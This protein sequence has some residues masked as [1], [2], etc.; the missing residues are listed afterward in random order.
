MKRMHTDMTRMAYLEV[1]IFLCSMVTFMPSNCETESENSNKRA[2]LPKFLSEL[3]VSSVEA[4]VESD[5]SLK[6]IVKRLA[7]E[8]NGVTGQPG[9]DF[10]ALTTIPVTS[11][12]CRGLKGGYYADLET[13][14]QVFHICDNGR[15]ISF[16][17]PNGTIFQQS[18]LICDWWF[19]VDCSKSTELYEQSSEELEEER[20]RAESRKPKLDYQQSIENGGQQDY[21]DVQNL[22]YDGRQNG[23]IKTYERPPEN[24]VQSNRERIKQSRHFDTGNNFHQESNVPRDSNLFGAN[25]FQSGQASK[26]NQFAR[27]TEE[28]N[29]N[30]Y[31]TT[32][33]NYYSTPKKAQNYHVTSRN[34]NNQE[35]GALKRLKFKSSTR[36]NSV[37]TVSQRVT[38]AYTESTTFRAGNTTPIKESQQVAESA[39]F[40]GNRA[41]RFD[42]NSGNSHQ[43]YYQL[44]VNRDSSTR[45][46]DST[47]WRQEN[48]ISTQREFLPL[49]TTTVPYE[50][51][52]YST[53]APCNDEVT[54]EITVA[55]SPP[56]FPDT[57]PTTEPFPNSNY[58]YRSSQGTTVR[59]TFVNYYASDNNNDRTDASN[60]GTPSTTRSYAIV[61][62]YRRN[63]ETPSSVYLKFTTPVQSFERSTESPVTGIVD[64]QY[65]KFEAKPSSKNPSTISPGYRQNF[66]SSTTEKPSRTTVFYQPT[67]TERDLSPYDR[68][69]TYKQGKVMSTLGPYVPF[70]RNYYSNSTTSKPTPY[71]PTVPTYTSAKTLIPKLKYPTPTTLS[72]LK[73]NRLSEREHALS[74]LHSLR[75]LEHKVPSL[76]DGLKVEERRSNASAPP[77]PSTLHSLALYFSTVTE[78]FE[79]NETTDSS[80]NFE[81]EEDVEKSVITKKSNGTVQVPAGLLTEHTVNSY[82]ELFKL[83]DSSDSNNLTTEDRSDNTSYS[84][85]YN[86]DLELQQS[87]GS[88]DE[89]RKSNSTKLRELAQVFTHALSAYLLDP[90]SFKRVLTEIRPTEPPTTTEQWRTTTAYSDAEDYT[91]S[92]KEKD[93][94]LEFSDDNDI[95]QK[96]T[97]DYSTTFEPSTTIKDNVESFSTLPSTYYTTPRTSFQDVYEPS[98]NVVTN[99]ATS[100]YFDTSAPPTEDT[101]TADHPSTSYA[102]D[103]SFHSQKIGKNVGELVTDN[104]VPSD[105]TRNR[106]G[107]FQN[108]S[109][110]I[111]TEPYGDKPFVTTPINDNHLVSP[112]PSAPSV[113]LHMVTHNWKQ[114]STSK[115]PEQ[116]LTPPY[117][118]T[119]AETVR[120]DSERIVSKPENYGSTV[121]VR[122]STTSRT[123]DSSTITDSRTTDPDRITDSR[124]TEPSR[125]TDSKTTDPR[126]H[127]PS[128]HK[129]LLPESKPVPASSFTKFRDL[130]NRVED[131]TETTERPLSTTRVPEYTTTYTDTTPCSN[132]YTESTNTNEESKLNDDHWT[133]SPAVTRLWET[134]VFVDPQ[135][136]NHGLE[137]DLGTT[138]LA[139]SSTENQDQLDYTNMSLQEEVSD[140]SEEFLEDL[141]L[142]QRLSRD[143][144]SPTTFSLFPTTFTT[145]TVTPRPLTT[146]PSITTIASTKSLPNS[147]LTS[148]VSVTPI[149]LSNLDKS[150][151]TE[152][153]I[154]E[155]L[156]GKL[157]VSSTNTLMRVMKQADSNETVRQLVLLLVQHCSD[158]ANQTMQRE[159]EEL[160]KTLLELPVNEFSSEESKNIVA[161]INQLSLPAR[162]N[163]VRSAST[164]A[165]VTDPPVT[166]YRSRKSRKF[167][168]TTEHSANFVRRAEK[169]TTNNSLLEDETTVS[170]NRA[171]ELLRSLYTIA[172]KW[173]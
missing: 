98:T 38:P 106:V 18:Q 121:T 173:G 8:K 158:L 12:S 62:N 6:K 80:I 2:S 90:D 152:S 119:H 4:S 13:N 69:F 100:V 172:T 116:Q 10:P 96:L 30:R 162:S 126:A 28:G 141:P 149:G 65:N 129:S 166:T 32:S 104:Y 114:K 49:V 68:S 58:D 117:F 11:F 7:P 46:Y 55:T 85:D 169:G 156:F 51:T 5:E 67:M 95:R 171:L 99:S 144:D 79:S 1:I 83:N 154:A 105:E 138:T 75:N 63:T 26:F 66:I 107:G 35:K 44:Y 125:I 59:S 170:D 48:D 31:S 64:S 146:R 57:P 23:R 87:G 61:D 50:T 130:Y 168:T 159:K 118:E 139:D 150:N 27:N 135:R 22:N 77:A 19:K 34:S 45:N 84:E 123:T 41:N 142:T 37:P 82:V 74:M 97:T 33:Q 110:S 53:V 3:D 157:N 14:C 16:L 131:H 109:A 56:T 148:T 17:C 147:L 70:T 60:S 103:T 24:Q 86:D 145:E 124:T 132:D 92:I 43:Y 78:N 91:S 93:E 155:K 164:T 42:E 71:T 133:S 122:S 167:R 25:G 9:V 108:N 120:R 140:S 101:F 72:K 52:Q 20:R 73:N 21:Y 29:V 112:T 137:S 151:G 39:A 94:V 165:V 76:S 15:K 113:F 81:A 102:T 160:L 163:Q 143:R 89:L 153:E 115:K 47:T 136:I 134:S 40:V 36:S 128:H 54:S 111:I 161:G 88:L 127:R